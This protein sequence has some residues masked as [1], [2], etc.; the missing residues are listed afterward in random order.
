MRDY[1]SG[2][3]KSVIG[4]LK[5]LKKFYPNVDDWIEKEIERIEDGKSKCVVAQ[6]DHEIVG[7]AISALTEYPKKNNVVKLKTFFLREDARKM[8]IGPYLLNHVI[9]FWVTKKVSKIYVTFAE[10][11]LEEL[12]LFFESY[13]FLFD[14]VSPL[15]YRNGFSEYIMSKV[16]VYKELTEKDFPSF[17]RNYI[18]RLRG[19]KIVEDIRAEELIVER[20]NGLKMPMRIYVR[21]YIGLYKWK[22]LLIE[23]RKKANALR[24]DRS[25]LVTYY[26]I[27][28]TKEEGIE[29]IDGY[30][31]ENIFYPLR[32][33]RKGKAG[34]VEPIKPSYASQLLYVGSQT[35]LSP[36]KKALRTDKVFFKY[37]DLKKVERGCIF[38]FYETQPTKAIIGEGKIE[39]VTV[40]SPE[41]LYKMYGGKGV[42]SLSEIRS[43]SNERNQ[44]VAFYMGKT[45]RYPTK[46][47]IEEIEEII[48]TFNPQGARYIS[49]SELDKIRKA[50]GFLL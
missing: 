11:E 35:L 50:G 14:G 19:F 4:L 38:V 39:K 25:I 8:G 7:V 45:T 6:I 16:F 18:L 31:I 21:I 20:V 26:P 24:C 46:I 40:D 48:P 30:D 3:R 44:V 23:T 2:D 33:R 15:L 10:E 9:D 37:P 41:S 42:L 5:N 27:V 17:V 43:Y 32:L 47:S 34:F 13:G 12:K 29:I 36:Y 22:E 49:Q 1:S 28:Q